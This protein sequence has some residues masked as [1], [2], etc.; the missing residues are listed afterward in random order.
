MVAM[1]QRLIN[2]RGW[3]HFVRSN[4]VTWFTEW[5]LQFGGK[6]AHVV[7]IITTLYMSAELYPGIHLPDG[8][9]VAVF[10]IQMFA[11]DMGGMGLASLSRQARADGNEEGARSAKNLS[12]WL[13][14]IMIAGLVTVCLEQAL[15]HLPYVQTIQGYID[16]VKIVVE[17]VL[18]V[19]R[20]VCAVLYGKTIHSLRVA[21][22]ASVPVI[23]E[24]PT[25]D[26]QPL[27]TKIAELEAQ[28]AQLLAT[29]LE[30]KE[31]T[32]GIESGNTEDDSVAPIVDI[33]DYRNAMKNETDEGRFVDTEEHPVVNKQR[34]TVSRKVSTNNGRGE[35]RQKALRMLKKNPQLTAPELAKKTGITRQYA[36]KLIRERE[37]LANSDSKES[38]A[39]HG[40]V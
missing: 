18:V 36:S 39:I 29:S 25:V 6:S 10:L 2:S 19:A 28:I 35:A 9:S 33:E 24:Q 32:E 8:L 5:L 37:T 17:L 22:P 1:V 13:I 21:E 26:L 23:P 27:H 38:E 12:N 15:S 3:Q 31:E 16:A 20:A 40:L 7:L 30:T 11:L 34:N 4:Y 14:G